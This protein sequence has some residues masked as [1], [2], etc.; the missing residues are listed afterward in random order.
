MVPTGTFP[1]LGAHLTG[2]AYLGCITSRLQQPGPPTYR[3]YPWTPAPGLEP[4]WLF[5]H[6]RVTAATQIPG[7]VGYELDER[8]AASPRGTRLLISD[9]R[10]HRRPTGRS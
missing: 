3:Y 9:G 2:S 5:A 7:I 1:D 10:S 4:A 6:T 8:T